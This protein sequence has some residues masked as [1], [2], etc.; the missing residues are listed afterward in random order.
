MNLRGRVASGAFLK[1]Q[2]PAWNFI[3]DRFGSPAALL[4]VSAE[5]R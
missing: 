3:H 1:P 5:T 2:H 4:S